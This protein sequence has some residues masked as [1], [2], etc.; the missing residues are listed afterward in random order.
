MVAAKTQRN[1][2]Q[3]QSFIEVFNVFLTLPPANSK[4]GRRVGD[5]PQSSVWNHRSKPR[6]LTAAVCSVGKNRQTDKS[7]FYSAERKKGGRLT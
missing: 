7:P 4:R 1:R 3:H 6:P 2:Q 5:G